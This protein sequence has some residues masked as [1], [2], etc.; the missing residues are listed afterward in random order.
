[1][2]AVDAYFHRASIAFALSAMVIHF[3][4]VLQADLKVAL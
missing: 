3:R 1:M 2:T 4:L